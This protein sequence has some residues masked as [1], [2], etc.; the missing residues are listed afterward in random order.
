MRAPIF[1][2]AKRATLNLAFILGAILPIQ[3]FAKDIRIGIATDQ[4]SAN[5]DVGRDYLAGAR[6]YFDHINTSGGINGRK[7]TVVVKD[8]EGD[9]AGTVRATREL[10]EVERVD[11]LFGYVGDEGISALAVDPVFNASRITLFA[12]LAGVE[13]K[14][15]RNNI[16]FMRPT[17]RDEASYIVEHFRAL[18]NASFAIVATDNSIGAALDGEAARA[19]GEKGN[20]TVTRIKLSTDLKNVDSVIRAITQAKAQVI[21]MAADTISMAGFL[22]KFRE[23]DKGSNVVGFSTINHRTLIELAKPDFAMSTVLTQVVPHPG[24]NDTKLQTEHS[25]LMK[26]YRDEPPS[27]V[28]LEGFAAAKA[29]VRALERSRDTSRAAIFASFAGEKSFNL[30]GLTLV[31]ATNDRRGSTFVDLAFLRKNGQLVQ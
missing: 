15:A 23:N 7:I 1:Q 8:D 13:L 14:G 9:A 31:Y 2:L 22:R 6:T 21:I 12:P 24:A 28:T 29:L 3:S 18:G 10:I 27:H 19:L 5:A 30:E 20:T 17:Y 26:R 16:V 25:A 4:S 11:V